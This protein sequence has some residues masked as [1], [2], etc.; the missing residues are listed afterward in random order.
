MRFIPPN[1]FQ[2]SRKG[3]TLIELLVVLAII[4]I[5]IVITVP[6]VGNLRER[7]LITEASSDCRAIALAWR[8]Y[9]SDNGMWPDPQAFEAPGSHAK[10]TEADDG[11]VFWEA[12]VRLL[13][14]DFHPE[15]AVFG[16]YNPGQI[17]YLNLP[18]D[19]IDQNNE[20]IDPWGNPYKFKLDKVF[21]FDA[22]SNRF[23]DGRI[24]DDHRIGRFPYREWGSPEDPRPGQIVVHDIAIAWSRGPNGMDHHPDYTKNEPRS[25]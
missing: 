7:A 24:T 9:Y 17:P 2:P 16:E 15:D 4:G 1:F 25:W 13:T 6:F 12:Y 22:D 8:L 5:L 23:L 18:P 10:S 11:E 20:F 19:R 3:F 14:G 21:E